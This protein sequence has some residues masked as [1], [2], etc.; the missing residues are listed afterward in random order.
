M[1]TSSLLT[2]AGIG[3]RPGLVEGQTTTVVASVAADGVD[4][5]V[6]VSYCDQKV[7]G[8]GSFDVVFL[9]KLRENNEPVAI[10]K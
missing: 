8:N 6:E 7:V 1:S 2:R 9:A 3:G 5:Q 4:Q 10:K